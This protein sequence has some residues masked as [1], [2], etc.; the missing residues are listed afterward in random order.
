MGHSQKDKCF[1]GAN[2]TILQSSPYH[3]RKRLSDNGSDQATEV[4]L[5][6][7]GLAAADYFFKFHIIK[8]LIDVTES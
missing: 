4:V 5:R 6:A 7:V 8:T 2:A 1:A 3:I